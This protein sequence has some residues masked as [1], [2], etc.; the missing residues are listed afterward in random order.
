MMQGLDSSKKYASCQ[1]TT[2]VDINA[3]KVMQDRVN[4]ITNTLSSVSSLLMQNRNTI[5]TN[6]TLF[7]DNNLEKLLSV[8]NQLR[9]A[10]PGV[11]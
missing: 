4:S 6:F 9:K 10:S 1:A 11:N 5:I 7:K 8:R 2:R 3:H